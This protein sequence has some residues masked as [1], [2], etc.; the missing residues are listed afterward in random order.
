[1]KQNIIYENSVLRNTNYY[2]LCTLQNLEKQKLNN[3]T[4]ILKE[5][6]EPAKLQ[7][8]L[9]LE[10]INIPNQ[11]KEE[12]DEKEK[13]WIQKIQEK[14]KEYDILKTELHDLKIEMKTQ[15]EVSNYKIQNLENIKSALEYEIQEIE[16]K[17]KEEQEP[18]NINII[19]QMQIQDEEIQRE[20]DNLK[21]E[22]TL[23]TINNQ[24]LQFELIRTIKSM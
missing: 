2:L 22:N 16:R 24:Q 13:E 20:I 11:K 4:T 17:G 7:Y 3:L 8:D 19:E 23:L 6:E 21:R 14:E 18:R 15:K 10:N 5:T 9:D 12:K 1:M